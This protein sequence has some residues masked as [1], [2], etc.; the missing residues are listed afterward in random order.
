VTLVLL[1]LLL[2]LLWFFSIDI[3]SRSHAHF[4]SLSNLIFPTKQATRESTSRVTG[5]ASFIPFRVDARLQMI[6][7]ATLPQK[8]SPPLDVPRV[9]ILA[10]AAVWI[11]FSIS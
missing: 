5:L 1:L 10:A 7:L 8:K 2:L 9:E 6:P 4:L 11:L 3:S